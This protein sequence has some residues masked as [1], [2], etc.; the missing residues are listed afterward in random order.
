MAF[1]KLVNNLS[2]Q[3]EIQ[4]AYWKAVF[5]SAPIANTFHDCLFGYKHI[6]V[7]FENIFEFYLT[8]LMYEFGRWEN[9]CRIRRQFYEVSFYPPLIELR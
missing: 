6:L 7:Q 4:Y 8:I 3:K 5:K 9:I 1:F 2:K